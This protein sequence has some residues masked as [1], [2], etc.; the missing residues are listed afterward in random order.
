LFSDRK[1]PGVDKD[2]LFY[3][4]N[5]KG[6]EYLGIQLLGAFVIAVWGICTN[7]FLFKTVERLTGG[8]RV[9]VVTEERGIDEADHATM[10]MEA[11]LM[12]QLADRRGSARDSYREN[13]NPMG[14][15]EESSMLDVMFASGM[16]VSSDTD[17]DGTEKE[18]EMK[19]HVSFNM[20][21]VNPNS[22][23]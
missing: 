5:Q 9:D 23:S 1:L 3:S 17:V 19:P 4:W 11:K 18:V 7:L 6:A 2:G 22:S 12:G 21:A 13:F 10:T 8:L 14:L 20:D 16:P 15:H